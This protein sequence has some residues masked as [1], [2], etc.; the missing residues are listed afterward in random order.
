MALNLARAGFT[1]HVCG[2][3]R[4]RLNELVRAAA[5]GHVVV[6]ESVA[7]A[8]AAADRFVV[9]MLTDM[10][11]IQSAFMSPDVLARNVLGGKLLLNT[12][13]ILPDESLEMQRALETTC[14]C[15]YVEAPVSGSIAQAETRKLFVL[16]GAAQPEVLAAPELQALVQAMGVPITVGATGAAATLKLALNELIASNVFGLS[17]ALG[18]VQG[19]GVP[20]DV[21]MKVVMSGPLQCAYYNI[22]LKKMLD[23]DFATPSFPLRLMHKDVLLMLRSMD[24]AGVDARYVQG[25]ADVMQEALDLGLGD[26]DFS[27]LHAIVNKPKRGGSSS[28]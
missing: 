21:L 17:V 23:R 12:T 1:V 5:A 10:P 15:A 26:S 22:K 4:A 20:V 9:L 27:V 16:L 18:I 6:H 11:T 19:A 13:T 7:Q 14:G 2:R 24:K 3:N 25:M 8:C 28:S